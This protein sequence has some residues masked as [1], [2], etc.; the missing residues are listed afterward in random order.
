MQINKSPSKIL[1][2]SIATAAYVGYLPWF[3]GT[4]ASLLTMFLVFSFWRIDYPVLSVLFWLSMVIALGIWAATW[5]DR[6]YKTHDAS[7]IVI[8]EVAGQIVALLPLLLLR[9]TS[10]GWYTVAVVL[11]RF[12]DIKKPWGIYRLQ[13]L[14]E[15]FGVMAD[16]LLAGCYAALFTVGG[17]WI[18]ILL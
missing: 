9:E 4:W 17:I 3:P 14:P 7:A 15:G 12:F 2:K 6:S 5:Y 10:W 1:V 11:F 18:K 16:D 13:D 8:D